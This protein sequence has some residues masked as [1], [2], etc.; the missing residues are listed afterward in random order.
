MFSFAADISSMGW[1]GSMRGGDG[2]PQGVG[3]RQQ[4]RDQA[5]RHAGEPKGYPA[6][7]FPRLG[8]EPEPLMSGFGWFGRIDETPPSSPRKLGLWKRLLPIMTALLP[9][10]VAIGLVADVVDG[11]QGRQPNQRQTS[12]IDC[13]AEECFE[14]DPNVAAT[15]SN[16][17][18]CDVPEK[19]VCLV[20]V[21]RTQVDLL[22]SVSFSL[23]SNLGI[24]VE[25]LPPLA[26]PADGLNQERHQYPSDQIQ[27]YVRSKY[28][29]QIGYSGTMLVIITPVDIY[30][31]QR[32]NWRYAFGT[33][34]TYPGGAAGVVSTARFGNGIRTVASRTQK[35]VNKYVGMG[36]YNLPLS[37]DPNSPLY[38]NILSVRDL[39]KMSE[40]LPITP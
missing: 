33:F 14:V 24:E 11:G 21:G 10:L 25:V 39:D 26:L 36:Y 4:G 20:P 6:E 5:S 23:E 1:F 13:V 34:H 3:G 9:L 7:H 16:Q 15:F 31:I 17:F 22:Q 32:E 19:I 18:A 30:T 40:R 29:T 2:E 28:Q 35:M 38:N 27:L 8:E 37:S 12:R